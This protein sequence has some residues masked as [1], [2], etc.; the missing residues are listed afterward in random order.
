[1]I[2]GVVSIVSYL[3]KIAGRCNV[4]CMWH[5]CEICPIYETTI[6]QSL[7]F[8]EFL[9]QAGFKSDSSMCIISIETIESSITFPF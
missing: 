6:M 1:M 8:M 5:A 7:L 2:D 4:Y 9:R 3:Q